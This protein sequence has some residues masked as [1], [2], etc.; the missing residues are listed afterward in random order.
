MI[1]IAHEQTA[2]H[3]WAVQMV[4]AVMTRYLHAPAPWH[5]EHGLV[6][7]GIYDTG[8]F[9][10]EPAFIQFVNDWLD[11][12]IQPDGAIL[13]YRMDEYNLDQ[14]NPGRLIFHRYLETGET[15]FMKA[16][17]LLREQLRQQPRTLSGG[18]WHKQIY[19]NQMWLDGLYMG[20]PFLAEFA[21]RFG[22]ADLFDD[23]VQQFR[24]V[25]MQTRDER[26]GLLVHGW[27]E[28]RKQAWADP[29]TGR[30][31]QVWGRAMGWYMMALVDVL[32]HFPAAHSGCGELQAILARCSQALLA[33]QDPGCG[34]WYQVL[35]QGG[36]EG[37]YLESSCTA[38]FIYAFA[39]AV[40]AGWLPA[41]YLVAG[42]RAY[43]GLLEKNVLID[44]EGLLS[45]EKTCGA[46][47]LGGTPYRDGSYIYYVTEK[48][49]TNDPKGTGA[50]ILAALQM[51]A[52]VSRQQHA[53]S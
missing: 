24:L 32:D 47:G 45:L 35:D 53:E 28:S 19:P 5:Y 36:R 38:M 16:L 46:A 52:A 26:T 31:P 9:Y 21:S 22:E 15:R 12:F 48:Q 3:S 34:M 8:Q 25:E 29:Q 10:H 20:Q 13:T 18:F 27:D 1:K 2:N 50:F 37:N 42:Q 40:R 4:N 17:Q 44:A 14:V 51:E 7:K 6:L 39:R 49:F 23:I 30:S 33:V 41:E 11:R 43:R